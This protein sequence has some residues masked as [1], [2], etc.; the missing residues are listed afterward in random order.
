MSP[1]HIDIGMVGHGFMGRAHAHALHTLGHVAPPSRPVRLAVLAGRDPARTERMARQL[2]F[3]RWTTDWR[4]AVADERVEIVANLAPNDLHAVVSIAALE[5][6]KHVVCEKPLGRDPGESRRMLEAAVTSGRVHACSFNY[7][8]APAVALASDLVRAGRIGRPVHFR[9]Q[10]LQD[11]GW[12]APFGWHFDAERTG[13]GAIGD[14]AHVID[15]ARHLVGEIEEV[16]AHVATFVPER[17]DDAGRARE[18]TVEDAY[19]ASGRFATGAL[20]NLECSRMAHGR[21]AHQ[22]FEVNG[23][24]GTIRWELEDFNRLRVLLADDAE[25]R[26]FRDV[27]VTEPQHPFLRWWWPTGHVLGWEHTF[28]H[29]WAGILE[30]VAG[31][32]PLP[33]RQA[34]FEDGWRA[35]L[36]VAAIG[37]AA[38]DRR[39]VAVTDAEPQRTHEHRSR[40]HHA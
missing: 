14:Y 3:E 17:A 40:E 24:E 29:Q 15:M 13:T 9:A 1:P 30:A 38:R 33:A 10:Y 11:W 22:T 28:V 34:T 19:V 4:E 7:R 31:A 20:L 8:F 12:R 25:P 32:A 35:D 37:R 36:V 23:E 2:G 5:A 26:S 16:A 6:G 27:L 18:V 21:K 39:T